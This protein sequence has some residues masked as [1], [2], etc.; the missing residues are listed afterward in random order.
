MRGV[1]IIGVGSTK[2]GILEGLS[3]KELAAM[4]CQ[5]AINDAG[6]E[7]KELQAFYGILFRAFFW[8]RRP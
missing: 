1:S 8:D 4:A 6:V 5:E 7:K 2:F 3:L